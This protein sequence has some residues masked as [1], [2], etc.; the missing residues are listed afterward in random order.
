M[1]AGAFLL[2][3]VPFGYLAGRMRGVDLRAHG[4]GNIGATNRPS[5]AAVVAKRRF[6]ICFSSVLWGG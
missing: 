1:L 4:S 5:A 6:F 3:A 2:G